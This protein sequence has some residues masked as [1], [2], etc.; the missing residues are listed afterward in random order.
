MSERVD[1]LKTQTVCS[2][3]YSVQLLLMTM[4]HHNINNS[5]LQLLIV[6]SYEHV[7]CFAPAI[8]IGSCPAETAES[9]HY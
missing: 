8:S 1:E 4:S 5:S 7:L 3:V 9:L 2:N 6:G